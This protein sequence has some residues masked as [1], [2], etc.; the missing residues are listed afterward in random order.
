MSRQVNDIRRRN[1]V[2]CYSLNHCL[3]SAVVLYSGPK[4]SFLGHSFIRELSLWKPTAD[5]LNHGL[6]ES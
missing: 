6:E 1:F 3:A 4:C 2:V 5:F